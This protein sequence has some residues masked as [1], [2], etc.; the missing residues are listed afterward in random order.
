MLLN[1]EQILK[2]E[3]LPSETVQVP[4]WGGE[5]RVRTMRGDERD[6]FE[7]DVFETRGDKV[8]TNRKNFRAKLLARTIVDDKNERM[9]SDADIKDLGRKSAKAL[10]RIF[11][12][13]Q[14][15]NGLS[16]EDEDALVK[17]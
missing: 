12:V 11:A 5:V 4:E 15:L 16:K 8:Q 7:A 6:D 9:F 17:N 13:A 3:D 1:K 10:D 14:R 2:V